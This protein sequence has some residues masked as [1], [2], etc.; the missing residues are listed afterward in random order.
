[1]ALASNI[2]RRGAIYYVRLTI[3]HSLIDRFERR[4]LWRSLRT[5]DPASARTQAP[6]LIARARCLFEM[7]ARDMTLTKERIAELVRNFYDRELLIDEVE[8]RCPAPQPLGLSAMRLDMLQHLEATLADHLARGEF[9]LIQ[10]FADEAIDPEGVA[11]LGTENERPLCVDRST[12]AYRELCQ[13]LLRARLEATRRHIERHQGNWGGAPSDPL[14]TARTPQTGQHAFVAPSGS[15][16]SAPQLPELPALPE[17]VEDFLAMKKRGGVNPKTLGEMNTALGWFMAYFGNDRP[18]T[19]FTRK[20]IIT[21]RDDLMN[22]PAHWKV[23]CKG[24][25][26]KEACIYGITS[27]LPKLDLPALK[28]KRWGPVREFWAWLSER[29]P[30]RFPT[31][32]AN[33]I[34]MKVVKSKKPKRD[35]FSA[36]QLN[37]MF[38]APVFVGAASE[39]R[40]NVPG[41][42]LIRNHRY[43]APL[44]ALFSGCRRG[45][46]CQLLVSDIVQRKGVWCFSINE[47]LDSDEEEEVGKSLKNEFSTR[48]VPIHPELHKLGFLAYVEQRR[49]AG[50]KRL[51][52]VDPQ[53]SY[54]AFGKWF[55]RFLDAL[56]IKSR[57]LVFHSFRHNFEQAMLETIPDY[58]LR[59][60]LGGRT[61]DHSSA[62]YRGTGYSVETRAEAVAKIMYPGF[63]VAPS[64]W[65]DWRL[66]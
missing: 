59:W 1:M 35:P 16:A 31:D 44:I 51:F 20:D 33:D 12:A 58:A 26:I 54:D 27:D 48:D 37:M 4:E 57:R 30:E 46:V 56:G 52:D 38:R 8:R 25:N 10:D 39:R 47:N 55:S 17:L 2:I 15:T 21:Y 64:L 60:Q 29:E 23:R 9:A 61:D 45:E 41:D 7:V 13:G 14:L 3:P 53:R 50:E 11:F 43:W 19:S 42:V 22:L 5:S 34:A 62:Q 40:W 18:V 32:P 63:E 28:T 36:E 65:T 49:N 66:E 24:M 6:I